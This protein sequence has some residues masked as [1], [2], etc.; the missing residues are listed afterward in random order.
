MKI[1]TVNEKTPQGRALLAQVTRTKRRTINPF[2]FSLLEHVFNAL[3][4]GIECVARLLASGMTACLPQSGKTRR[5][6]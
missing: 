4:D 1:I 5:R 6:P 3:L 2:P